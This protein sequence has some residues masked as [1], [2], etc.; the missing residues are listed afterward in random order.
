MRYE[1]IQTAPLYLLLVAVG[2]GMLGAAWLTPMAFVRIVL[3]CSGALMFLLAGSFRQLTVRDAGD[4]LL[5]Q[6][7][8][9]PLFRRRIWYAEIDRVQRSRT[10][11]LDGWGVHLSPSGGWTWNLWGFDCVDVYYNHRKKVRIGTDD[12]V[13]LEEF[14]QHQIAHRL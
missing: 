13:R 8:P 12:A 4:H 1:H 9:L 2:V 7:G 3:L 11:V 6:F 14:L 10:T 5:I